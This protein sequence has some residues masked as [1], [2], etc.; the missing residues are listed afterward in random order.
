MKTLWLVTAAFLLTSCA[1]QTPQEKEREQ[2]R[3]ERASRAVELVGVASPY[4]GLSALERAA[5]KSKV[6]KIARSDDPLDAT[7]D[8][9]DENP[10]IEQ[11]A[12]EWLEDKNAADVLDK[13]GRS[14]PKLKDKAE[15][16]LRNN[17]RMNDKVSD[18]LGGL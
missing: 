17:P 5:L 11:K 8:E 14:N 6:G 7:L 15:E 2:R 18:I 16:W 1:T 12:K 13:I 3:N 9:L 4:L 10:Q